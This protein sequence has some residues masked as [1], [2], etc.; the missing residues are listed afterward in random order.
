MEEHSSRSEWEVDPA[1]S[2][3]LGGFFEIHEPESRNMRVQEEEPSS[4]TDHAN[5]DVHGPYDP[6]GSIGVRLIT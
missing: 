5:A 2:R 1:E 3:I 6:R 4:E